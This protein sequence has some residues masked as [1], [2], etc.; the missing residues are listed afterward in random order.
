M[1]KNGLNTAQIIRETSSF[2][3]RRFLSK[4]DLK[5][6]RDFKWKAYSDRK[7]FLSLFLSLDGKIWESHWWSQGS[8]FKSLTACRKSLKM[9]FEDT[10][11]DFVFGRTPCE[12]IKALKMA[13]ILGY[14]PIKI[15]WADDGI[16][17]LI[18]RKEKL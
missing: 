12:N 17:Y 3:L 9:F 2:Y 4:E 13:R 1:D 5:F 7:G 14:Q 11:V 10:G 16:P 6:L 15:D 18:S 8:A